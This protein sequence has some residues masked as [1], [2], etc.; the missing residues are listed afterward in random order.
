MDNRRLMLLLVGLLSLAPGAWCILF[1]TAWLPR[2]MTLGQPGGIPSEVYLRVFDIALRIHAVAAL[3][4]LG[5]GIG[6][7]LVVFRT[8]RVP[9]DKKPIWAALLIVGNIVA[10]P[11]FWY[12]Y[13]WRKQPVAA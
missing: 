5:L 3:L 13:V 2:L 11:V 10:F 9:P 12:F 4:T 6:F 7:L 8:A 1:A